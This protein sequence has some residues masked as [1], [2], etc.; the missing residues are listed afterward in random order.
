MFEELVPFAMLGLICLAEFI[1]I[2]LILLIISKITKKNILEEATPYKMFFCVGILTILALLLNLK[3]SI[4]VFI[5]LEDIYKEIIFNPFILI[6]VQLTLTYFILRKFNFRK[7]EAS[8]LAIIIAIFT[9]AYFIIM[10]TTIY[11][12]IINS[13][14]FPTTIKPL[15]ELEASKV[16]YETIQTPILIVLVRIILPAII[17]II[18]FI[19]L[20]FDQT[21]EWDQTNATKLKNKIYLLV[22]LFILTIILL[23]LTLS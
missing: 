14:L 20:I 17:G 5:P 12:T 1:W 8:I 7:K 2:F 21:K 18:V 15:I 19:K 23:G 4:I 6:I 22:G 13:I 9:N 3:E 11:M 10:I 16:N